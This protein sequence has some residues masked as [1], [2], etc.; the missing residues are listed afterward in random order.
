MT[1]SVCRGQSQLCTP[2]GLS[3]S[4]RDELISPDNMIVECS[5]L[6]SYSVGWESAGATRRMAVSWSLNVA[7]RRGRQLFVVGCSAH[8]SVMALAA[9][10]GFW[11]LLLVVSYFYL[12][13]LVA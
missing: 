1:T 7:G 9:F 13:L 10:H 4:P 6:V 11:L 12:W 5:V 3:G 8:L 2:G